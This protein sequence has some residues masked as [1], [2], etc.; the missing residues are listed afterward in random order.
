MNALLFTIDEQRCAL[1]LAQVVEVVPAVNV[2]ALPDAPSMMEGVVNVRGEILPVLAVRARM[3][4]APR[5][6]HASEYFILVRAKTRRVIVRSDTTPEIV[7][8]SG[9]PDLGLESV[10]RA[11]A[12]VRPLPDG[13]ALF[14]DVDA[15]MAA[16]DDVGSRPCPHDLHCHHRT[17][18][19]PLEPSGICAHRASRRGSR[20]THVSGKSARDHRS[21]DQARDGARGCLGSGALRRATQQRRQRI[22]GGCYRAHH[23]RDVF[24]PRSGP[25]ESRASRDCTR[26]SAHASGRPWRSRLERGMRQRRG[27]LHA[28]HRAARVGLYLAHG[29][30]HGPLRAPARPRDARRVYEVVDARS[31]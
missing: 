9:V 2:Q 20:R 27:G 23:R 7:A 24:L 10:D 28:G 21:G 18:C 8:L 26:A 1:P 30:R 25:V 29:D 14:H 4:L 22:R 12:G 6:V 17:R 3:G 16:R 13:L 11:L 19:G 31:R 5:A 15:F